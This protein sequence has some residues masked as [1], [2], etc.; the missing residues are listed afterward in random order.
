[1]LMVPTMAA[2]VAETPNGGMPT[3]MVPM[4]MAKVAETPNGG[5]PTLMVPMMMAKVAETPNGGMPMLMVP[6][7]MAKVAETPN[8][9]MPRLRLGDTEWLRLWWSRRGVVWFT[10]PVAAACTPVW[11]LRPRMGLSASRLKSGFVG[12]GAGT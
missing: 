2:K 12:R 3:L 1:M 8:G 4:M 10:V 7:M 11:W 5:V 6:M 9:G